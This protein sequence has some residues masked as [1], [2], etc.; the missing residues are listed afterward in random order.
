LIPQEYW[1]D[2]EFPGAYV[3]YTHAWVEDYLLKSDGTYDVLFRGIPGDFGEFYSTGPYRY[4]SIILSW[5]GTHFIPGYV[6]LDPPTYRF[7]AVQDGDRESLRR[8]YE[9]ALVFYNQALNDPNLKGWPKEIYGQQ[10]DVVQAGWRDLLTPTPYPTDP[11]EKEILSAYIHYRKMLIYTV[12]GK[13][14][15]ALEE[16]LALTKLSTEQPGYAY[17]GPAITFWKKYQNSQDLAAACIKTQIYSHENYDELFDP[18]DQHW[19]GWDSPGY[20]YNKSLICPFGE[21]EKET[22]EPRP[23]QTATQEYWPP[24]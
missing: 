4:Y 6:Q 16:Y 7:Q 15:E 10:L 1:H 18:I 5:N 19:H 2:Y 3:T 11:N 22:P 9:K 24:E 17:K 21:I 14:E 23:T 12:Q 20:Y 8:N 13:Q